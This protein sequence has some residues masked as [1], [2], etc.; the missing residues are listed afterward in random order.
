MDCISLN[1]KWP[2]YEF[3]KRIPASEYIN[4]ISMIDCVYDKNLTIG[5]EFVTKV[6]ILVVKIFFGFGKTFK[7]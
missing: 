6:T 7:N 1:H 2:G 4:N 5:A 3:D